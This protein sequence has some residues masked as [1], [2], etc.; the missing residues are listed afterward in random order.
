MVFANRAMLWTWSWDKE[1]CGDS[2]DIDFNL[3]SGS[4]EVELGVV[5]LAWS[6]FG[7]CLTLKLAINAELL[8]G[9]VS[10]P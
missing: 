1:L 8:W 6:A 5:Q 2:I 9:T 7:G 3:L 4:W 10:S